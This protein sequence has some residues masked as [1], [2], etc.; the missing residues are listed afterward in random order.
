[1]RII[2]IQPTI[3]PKNV[4][5]NNISGTQTMPPTREPVVITPQF[6]GTEYKGALLGLG[7]GLVT[8]LL[9]VGGAAIAGAFVLPALVGGA[10]VVGTGIAGATIG[11]KIEEKIDKIK[12]KKASE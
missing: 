10:A 6:R 9:V 3:Q 4:Y 2:N 11:N 1:M 8:G 12:S 7:G 5:K